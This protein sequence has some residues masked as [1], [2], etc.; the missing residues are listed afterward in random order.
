MTQASPEFSNEMSD[1]ARWLTMCGRADTIG[2]WFTLPSGRTIQAEQ[3]PEVS[4]EGAK[5]M[6]VLEK[7][8]EQQGPD[9]PLY[10][11][12]MPLAQD[13]V[14]KYFGPPPEQQ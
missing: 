5:M 7:I 13:F 2:K 11:Q 9:H 10:R 12:Y 3:F 4:E 8:Q 6:F 14:T 1:G